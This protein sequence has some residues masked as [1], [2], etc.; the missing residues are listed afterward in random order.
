L[1]F[2][3]V[4]RQAPDWQQTRVAPQYFPSSW[5]ANT[6]D[7]GMDPNVVGN[8]TEEQWKEALS[9]IPSMSV[10]T[11]MGNLFDQTTGIYANALQQGE[12][13]ERPASIELLD[14]ANPIP[15][16]FQ[17]NCGLRIRGGFSRNPQF[18]KHAFRVFFR[19]E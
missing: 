10:V 17:E 13:W 9:Q 12:V 5:G 6:V 2:S 18:V 4:I 14:P 16:R 3:D 11:E 15:G 7:Y 8:Y 19:R 1:F